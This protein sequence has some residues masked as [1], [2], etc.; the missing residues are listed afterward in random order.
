M[1]PSVDVR[2]NLMGQKVGAGQRGLVIV[3]GKKL[4]IK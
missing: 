1:A 2:Y 4:L 3:N